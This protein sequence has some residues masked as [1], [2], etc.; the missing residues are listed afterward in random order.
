MESHNKE[1]GKISTLYEK[2]YGVTENTCMTGIQGT[3]IKG[4][5]R[6]GKSQ[7]KLCALFLKVGEQGSRLQL[8]SAGERSTY[9]GVSQISHL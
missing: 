4:K 3:K 8:L 1:S 5:V 2:D 9:L 6:E 7:D